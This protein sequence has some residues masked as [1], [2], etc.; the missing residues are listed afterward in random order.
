MTGGIKLETDQTRDV[1][2]ESRLFNG[3]EPPG[4][5]NES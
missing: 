2:N 5:G 3:H 4:I 1:Q